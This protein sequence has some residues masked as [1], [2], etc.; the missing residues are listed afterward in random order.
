MSQQ[1]IV[2]C[3]YKDKC[4]SLNVRCDSCGNN[5]GK[6]DYYKADIVPSTINPDGV[7]VKLSESV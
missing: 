5:T 2:Y 4:V 1:T 6:K 3:I 7:K